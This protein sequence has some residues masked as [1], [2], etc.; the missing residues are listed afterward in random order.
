[1]SSPRAQ[2][3]YFGPTDRSLFGWLH[4]PAA[5]V[6]RNLGL[7]LCS[8][9][10]YEAICTHRSYRHF[11]E[12][13]AARGFPAL[14]FD[15]DGTGDSAGGSLDADRL[16]H[17]LRSIAA[18]IDI[19]KETTGVERI[20]LFGVRV[21]ASLAAVAAQGRTDVE[22]LIAFAPVIKVNSYLR[23]T[24]ALALSRN[25]SEPPPE[26]KVDP[27]L[28]EAAGFTTTAETRAALANIDLAKLASA[29]AAHV[30]LLERDDLTQS[31]VWSSKLRHQSAVVEQG[32]LIGYTDMMRD[33]HASKVP[34]KAIASALEWLEQRAT[35]SA[36]I[37]PANLREPV[38]AS[39]DQDGV[40]VLETATFLDPERVLFG[41]ISEPAQRSEP[42]RD[43]VVLLNSGTINHI[44]PGRLYVAIARQCAAR[45][46]VVL[47]VDL[48]GVGDSGLRPGE[49]GNAAYAA[50]A[51]LDV[52]VAV[53]CAARRFPN[54]KLHLF[55]LCSGAYHGLKAA[56]AGLP[57]RSVVIVNPL[58]FF[59]KPG[60]SLEYSDFQVTAETKRYARSAG[61]LASWLKLLRGEV[62]LRNAATIFWKRFETRAKHRLREAARAF[63]IKTH[64]DLAAELLRVADQ[65]TDM[66]FV[67][68]ASDPGHALLLEQG[69]S[70]VRKLERQGRMRS[71]IVSGADHTFNQSWNRDQ[72]I[73]L[74]MT[75]L[76]RHATGA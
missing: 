58:T 44:G 10:G 4:R 7:V 20:C 30:L 76:D 18:A 67:F 17:W 14:R 25:Q 53:E 73:A 36:T 15:Y 23:E 9:S 11:A 43:V 26:L 24:R 13:A 61:S 64:E 22:A 3:L 70:T 31:D 68:S 65:H 21:G 34:V 75:H 42:I 19:L 35:V 56:A 49:A 16:G 63:G 66:F 29:P 50:S 40:P 74:L 52:R 12:E 27:E 60:M 5:D 41:I 33:A 38:D 28:Q 59:W 72:L 54:A 1:M 6:A 45:N 8:A 71:S 69:G 2:P 37:T 55:G 51:S 32:P 46:V 62:D 57:L 48:S 39:F 47:R